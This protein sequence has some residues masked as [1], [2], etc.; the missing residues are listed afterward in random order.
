MVL[1][2]WVDLCI[3]RR[4]ARNK[5]MV[6]YSPFISDW[7]FCE[8]GSQGTLVV[9]PA[10]GS[11]RTGLLA[12]VWSV[13]RTKLAFVHYKQAPIHGD[14][15]HPIMDGSDLVV[16]VDVV[17]GASVVWSIAGL[18]CPEHFS[19]VLPTMIYILPAFLHSWQADI[20]TNELWRRVSYL[21]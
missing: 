13:E 3:E 20:W 5:R 1:E 18:V 9:P 21:V 12:A 11:D 7:W 17:V 2:G 8:G 19:R 16:V 6:V 4:Q 14:R 15:N 10:I